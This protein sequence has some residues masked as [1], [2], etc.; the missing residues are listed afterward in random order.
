MLTYRQL[1]LDET[2]DIDLEELIAR[3]T[4]E[5]PY[6]GL[7]WHPICHDGSTVGDDDVESRHDDA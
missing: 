3:V 5:C 1:T 2:A 7:D 4:L 6:C